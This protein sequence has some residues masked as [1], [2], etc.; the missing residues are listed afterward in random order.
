MP[1]KGAQGAK[2]E[3]KV[4]KMLGCDE[5]GTDT[6]RTLEEMFSHKKWCPVVRAKK[7]AAAKAKAAASNKKRKNH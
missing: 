2:A 6:V 1:K 7:D 3:S 5:C 4:K